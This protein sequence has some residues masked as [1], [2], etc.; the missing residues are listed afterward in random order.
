M[1]SWE[2]TLPLIVSTIRSRSVLPSIVA[3]VHHRPACPC[4]WS[5]FYYLLLDPCS[6]LGPELTPC[7]QPRFGRALATMTSSYS[8]RYINTYC[9]L[10]CSV[11]LLTSTHKLVQLRMIHHNCSQVQ[12]WWA[13]NFAAPVQLHCILGSNIPV[14]ED[15]RE[16]LVLESYTAGCVAFKSSFITIWSQLIIICWH[17]SKWYPRRCLSPDAFVKIKKAPCQQKYFECNNEQ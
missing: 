15:M 2:L 13:Q 10:L 14:L 9:A 17:P 16:S 1:K 11:Y 8:F 5:C 4:P 3:E 12:L 6:G 7:I